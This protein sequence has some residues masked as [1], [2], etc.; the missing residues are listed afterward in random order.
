[1]DDTEKPWLMWLGH[2]SFLASLGGRPFLIDPV[3]SGHAGWLY[4][5]RLPPA[6]SIDRMPE[7]ETVLVTHNHYDHLDASVYTTFR[8][9][10]VVVVPCGMERWMRRRG[11]TRVIEL[12]WWQQ[13][14]IG[15]L[16]VTLVP[17]CHWS[18]RGVFDTN[19]V[20]WGGYVVESGDRSI[21]HSGD[22]AWFDGFAEIGRRFPDLDAALL[23]IGGYDPP[24]FMEHY[25]L[26][27]EQ[28]GRAF[29]ELK[30]HRLVPMHWGTFQLT[31]EPL[32]EPADRMRS[33]WHRHGPTN[34]RRLCFLDVGA[35]LELDA[36]DG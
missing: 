24:W 21:Y 20:L 11:C 23:P 14:D 31:D 13:A 18:R 1:M 27:P 29:L 36:R 9:R 30:A 5:R 32:C 17:A 26:N 2:A 33:W 8:D 34:S 4:E 35:T 3:F 22:S 28:A 25:H 15:G 19:R 7:V 10:A 12:Q 16:R 6:I